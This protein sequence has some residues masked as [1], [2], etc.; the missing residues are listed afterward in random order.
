ML[1][2]IL[3]FSRPIETKEDKIKRQMEIDEL[4]FDMSLREKRSFYRKLDREEYEK[5]RIFECKLNRIDPNSAEGKNVHVDLCDSDD[6][7]DCCES[8]HHRHHHKQHTHQTEPHDEGHHS[9]DDEHETDSIQQSQKET[10]D[11]EMLHLIKERLGQEKGVLDETGHVIE[12]KEQDEQEQE[13]EDDTYND[14]CEDEEED[15]DEYYEEGE[16]E[17]EDEETIARELAAASIERKEGDKIMISDSWD[18]L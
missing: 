3:L 9:D 15:E 13:Q 18:D 4:L 1:I 7:C 6:S 2:I 10:E 12:D 8:K 17:K 5:Q 14:E 16:E 11:A